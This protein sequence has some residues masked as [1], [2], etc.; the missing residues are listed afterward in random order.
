MVTQTRRKR[1]AVDEAGG[2]VAGGDVAAGGDDRDDAAAAAR[3]LERCHE[4]HRL[5]SKQW[6]EGGDAVPASSVGV[7]AATALRRLSGRGGER[8][9]GAVPGCTAGTTFVGKAQLLAL[10]LH[11]RFYSGVDYIP[12]G[13]CTSI[14]I[15]EGEY[16][17]DT[18]VRG[19]GTETGATEEHR[20]R[21]T[22]KAFSYCGQGGR[23][24]KNRVVRDQTMNAANA[25]LFRA[26]EHV[27]PIRVFRGRTG[28][29]GAS[30]PRSFTYDGLYTVTRARRETRGG[31][32]PVEPTV[33][34]YIFEL[35]SLEPEHDD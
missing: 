18:E 14:T 31:G 4:L 35:E 22:K 30:G 34:V 11:L 3:M 5:M 27:S 21:N 6:E 25:S 26:F 29:Y 24:L 7:R 17:Y 1:K 10:G 13:V 20:M 28:P 9:I 8:V 16:P 15:S 19:G 12:G 23:D 32:S 33:N 2:D